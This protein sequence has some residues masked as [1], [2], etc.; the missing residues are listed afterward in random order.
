MWKWRRDPTRS[1]IGPGNRPAHRRGRK[2]AVEQLEDRRLLSANVVMCS[3]NVSA[4]GVNSNETTLSPISVNSASFGKQFST[5]LDGNVYAEP[6]EESGVNITTGAQPGDSE[7]RICRHGQ[8][9]R[10]RHRRHQ[11]HDPLADER[12]Q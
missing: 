10:L 6:L 8:R 3:N 2:L 12:H 9:Q 7:R 5:P 1:S 11:R 4:T